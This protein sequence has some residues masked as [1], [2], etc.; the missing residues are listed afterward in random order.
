MTLCFLVLK[1][2]NN[3]APTKFVPWSLHIREGL[4]LRAMNLCKGAMNASIVRSDA[5]TALID[6]DTKMQMYALTNIGLRVDPYF[7]MNGP[8]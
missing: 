7:I 2:S 8:A 3:T 6:S 4:P 1:E 5:S